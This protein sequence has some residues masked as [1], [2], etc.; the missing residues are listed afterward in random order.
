MIRQTC[1]ILDEKA[2]FVP[3]DIM[4]R[5]AKGMETWSASQEAVQRRGSIQSVSDR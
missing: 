2:L 4:R 1:S 5:Q 3:F